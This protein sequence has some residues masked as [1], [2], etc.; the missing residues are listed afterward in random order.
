[1]TTYHTERRK[2]MD[3]MGNKKLALLYILH[4]LKEHSDADHPMT[5][6]DIADKLETHYGIVLERKAVSRNLSLLREAGYEIE[7]TAKGVY[8]DERDFD[9][10][11]LR[12]MIDGVLSSRYITEKQAKDLAT[13][14]AG[15]SNKHFRSHV[16]HIHLLADRNKTPNNTVFYTIERIDEAIE[17]GLQLSFNYYAY[18]KDLQLLPTRRITVSPIQMV[19]QNQYY[20]LLATE[21]WSMFGRAA[22]HRGGAGDHPVVTFYRLDLMSNPLIEDTKSTI[23]A[24]TLDKNGEYSNP[25]EFLRT[26]P[27]MHSYAH[28]SEDASFLCYE[29]NLDLVVETFGTDI[30]VQKIKSN[31]TNGDIDPSDGLVKIHLKADINELVEFACRYPQTVF[32]LSPQKAVDRQKQL[33]DAHNQLTQK[34]RQLA[35]E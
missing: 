22:A 7:S 5:Q 9:N 15:L 27:Y 13:R 21:T 24:N 20:Y 17:A 16:R 11:E 26:H 6:N 25:K 3:T 30:R 35:N 2:T 33:Y 12:L 8:L 34:F 14:I 19:V 28:P 32:L 29:Q 23:D 4:I 1:M 18:D 31:T 10:T